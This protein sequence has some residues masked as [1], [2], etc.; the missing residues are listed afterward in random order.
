[1]MRQGRGK[2]GMEVRSRLHEAIGQWAVKSQVTSATLT[3]SECFRTSV[4]FLSVDFPPMRETITI[5]G[6]SRDESLKRSDRS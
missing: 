6:A 2:F 4:D 1:M 5:Y 3:N